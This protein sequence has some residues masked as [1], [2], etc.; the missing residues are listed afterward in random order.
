MRYEAEY[1]RDTDVLIIAPTEVALCLGAL[2]FKPEE[3][4]ELD[5]ELVVP[6]RNGLATFGPAFNAAENDMTLPEATRL[7][8]GLLIDS[9]FTAAA[10]RREFWDPITAPADT[11]VV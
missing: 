7:E 5:E 9:L 4:D 2:G 11:P 1:G 8:Y 6:Y 3:T 10:D